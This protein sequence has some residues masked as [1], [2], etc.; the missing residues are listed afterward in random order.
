MSDGNQNRPQRVPNVLSEY[1]LRLTGDPINGSKR[2]PS[3]Q[4]NIKRNITVIDVRTGVENDKDYGKIS[5]PIPTPDFFAIMEQIL[6]FSE[7][8]EAEHVTCEIHAQRFIRAQNARSKE[9]MLEGSVTVGRSS[10]GVFIG[11]KSWDNERPACRFFFRPVVDNRNKTIFLRR[12]GSAVE[13]FE[14]SSLY[15][16]GWVRIIGEL[17]ALV[18]KDEFVPPP[19]PQGAGGGN[20]GYN[21]GGGG[22]YNNGGNRGG[23]GGGGGGNGGGGYN[24]GGGNGGGG[25]GGDNWEDGLPM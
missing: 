16:K 23:Y 8:G 12:D 14:L 24:N 18:L 5:L 17:T 15:A 25:G 21:R 6:K 3:L 22:G 13:E 19:P 10:K 20:G 7:P 11:V 9:P 1:K 2:P 4:V